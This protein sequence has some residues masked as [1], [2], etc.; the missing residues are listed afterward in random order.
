MFT[1]GE[2]NH[3]CDVGF[4]V[5]VVQWAACDHYGVGSHGS[6]GEGGKGGIVA[7]HGQLAE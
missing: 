5:G 2:A 7:G 4:A 3:R 1:V 6:G